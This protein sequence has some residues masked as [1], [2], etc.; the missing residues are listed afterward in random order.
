MLILILL[1]IIALL[2]LGILGYRKL[3]LWLGLILV[4]VPVVLFIIGSLAM[5]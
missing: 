4:I 2:L 1:I 3:A 5:P